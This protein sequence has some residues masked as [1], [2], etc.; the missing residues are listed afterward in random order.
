[1]S[2]YSA[3]LISTREEKKKKKKGS[4]CLLFSHEEQMHQTRILTRCERSRSVPSLRTLF[5][6]VN[7]RGGYTR[8]GGDFAGRKKG[9][10][11]Q[12]LRHPVQNSHFGRTREAAPS[13]RQDSSTPYL[14]VRWINNS[15]KNRG[16]NFNSALGP[17]ERRRGRYKN[18]ICGWSFSA[19]FDCK[20]ITTV[21]T[22]WQRGSHKHG[23]LI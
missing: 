13:I 17:G 11:K 3:F 6:Q 20:K 8:Y 10:L 5:R 21:T 7:A 14:T 4:S 23:G 15:K 19:N 18:V 2:N 1:M 16:A 9:S 12:K 22:N